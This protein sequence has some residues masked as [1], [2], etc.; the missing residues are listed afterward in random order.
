MI[1]YLKKESEKKCLAY[2][3]ALRRYFLEGLRKTREISVSQGSKS[4][5]PYYEVERNTE[6][7]HYGST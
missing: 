7:G 3:K 5:H 2:Y 1:G 6:P 4:A